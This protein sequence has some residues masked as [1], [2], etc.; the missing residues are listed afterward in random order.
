MTRVTSTAPSATLVPVSIA[1]MT[2]TAPPA[3]ATLAIGDA[4]VATGNLGV[5]TVNPK[6]QLDVR[7]YASISKGI[8]IGFA[9]APLFQLQLSRDSAAKP[10]TNTWTVYSDKRLK[11]DQGRADL[12]RCYEIVK[13][14]PL[15]RFAWKDGTFTG[16]QVPDRTKMGWY[17]QDI[18]A[19]FPKSVSPT[20]AFGM[21]DCLTMNSDQVIAALYGTV[22]ML[23]SQVEALTKKVAG[24][25][26][27]EFAGHFTK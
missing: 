1:A 8:G 4:I 15:S 13:S 11:N 26:S 12:K 21:K 19:V 5:G 9:N 16:D 20:D 25:E 14:L 23:Q 2:I 10:S 24:L 18:K 7:G 6:Q 22:Q 27:F 3:R 17:A